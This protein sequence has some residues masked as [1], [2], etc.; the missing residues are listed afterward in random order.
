M[1]SWAQVQVSDHSSFLKRTGD[2]WTGKG[3]L[4]TVGVLL[5]G[6]EIVTERGEG[7]VRGRE[8]GWLW[9]GCVGM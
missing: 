9:V 8:V 3:V 4:L 1:L 6:P 2:R 7:G 5:P